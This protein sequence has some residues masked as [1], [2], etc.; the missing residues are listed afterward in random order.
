MNA[1]EADVT[2]IVRAATSATERRERHVVVAG[3]D[4]LGVDLVADDDEIVLGGELGNPLQ[5]GS[6]EHSARR[7]LRMAEDPQPGSLPAGDCAA[8]RA[9][10]SS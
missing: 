7:V 8:S 3:V 2:V 6:L 1:F 10:S 9:S 5:L 4:E